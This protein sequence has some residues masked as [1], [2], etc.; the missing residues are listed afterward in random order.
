MINKAT[1]AEKTQT[2]ETAMKRRVPL[3]RNVWQDAFRD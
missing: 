3:E 1:E 2:F